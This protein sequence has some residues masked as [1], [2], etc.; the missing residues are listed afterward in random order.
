MKCPFEMDPSSIIKEK[1]DIQL[2][3]AMMLLYLEI[4]LEEFNC[5]ISELSTPHELSES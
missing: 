4:R 3:S 1:V 5:F 2:V